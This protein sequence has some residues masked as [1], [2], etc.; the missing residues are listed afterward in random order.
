[1]EL[2]LFVAIHPANLHPRPEVGRANAPP[3]GYFI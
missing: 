1:V 2:K 3:A